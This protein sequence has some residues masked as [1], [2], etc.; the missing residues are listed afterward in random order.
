MLV[1]HDDLDTE[2]G[3]HKLTDKGF[4]HKGH[5]GLKNF[6][7][8]DFKRIKIGISRPSSWDSEVIGEYCLSKFS[9]AE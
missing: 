6:G 9:M 8:M 5:N 1:I 3:K 2:L 7:K 4:S